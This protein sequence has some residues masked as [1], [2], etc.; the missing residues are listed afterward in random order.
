MKRLQGFTLIE[1]MIAVAILA[2]VTA[3]AIPAYNRYVLEGRFGAMRMNL[4]SLRI[5]VEGTRL[6]S[7]TGV[8]ST[9]VT[10]VTGTGL[11]TT[12][13]W[14]PEGD[15]DQYNYQVTA[16]TTTYSLQARFRNASPWVL[17]RRNPASVPVFR[18]C[19]GESGAPS[20]P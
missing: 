15:N 2:I 18:C 4:D 7:T 19:D 6:D 20:C 10:T 5:A 8:Y 13:G 11:N 14:R 12:F 9:A 3:I 16:G 17:C 1:L